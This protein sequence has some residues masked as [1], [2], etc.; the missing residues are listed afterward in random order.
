[1]RHR[2]KGRKLNITDSHRKAL[3]SN[4]AVALFR[5]EGIQTTLAKSKELRVIAEKLITLAK[6]GNLHARRQAARTIR[7]HEVLKKL[8]DEIGPRYLDRNGGYTRIIKL[9]PRFG[10]A[11]PMAYIEL[12]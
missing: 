8:F 9:G 12:V 5:Y 1:M 11:A 7:D 6:R 3:F 10:D 2:N 4:Q